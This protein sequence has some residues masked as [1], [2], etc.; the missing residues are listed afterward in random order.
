MAN[1]NGL[2]FGN[3]RTEGNNRPFFSSIFFFSSSLRFSFIL[4]GTTHE[5]LLLPFFTFLFKN[6]LFSPCSKTTHLKRARQG[7]KGN[8]MGFS[9]LK[10]FQKLSIGAMSREGGEASFSRYIIWAMGERDWMP[11]DGTGWDGIG[12][13]DA[14]ETMFWH[15]FRR[16]WLDTGRLRW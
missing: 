7:W 3:G 5:K 2:G 4:G 8:G 10:S 11:R 9:R 14:S 1:G 12:Y 16:A 15:G 6:F 13:C